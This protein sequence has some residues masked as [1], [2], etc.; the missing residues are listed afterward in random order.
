[1]E[2]SVGEATSNISFDAAALRTKEFSRLGGTTLFLRK[3]TLD[4]T[5]CLFRYSFFRIFGV[6]FLL[7]SRSL[8]VVSTVFHASW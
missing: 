7:V 4:P 8:F 2:S 6:S 5:I 1:M 3:I